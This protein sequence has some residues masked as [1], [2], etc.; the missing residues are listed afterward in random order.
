MNTGVTVSSMDTRL[1][2]V[3]TRDLQ[4]PGSML[5]LCQ[6]VPDGVPPGAQV[7]HQAVNPS[8]VL[9]INEIQPP[10]VNLPRA[11]I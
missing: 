1:D 6:V 10:P 2:Q 8:S 3:G 9:G 5:A 4:V 7:S 11:N